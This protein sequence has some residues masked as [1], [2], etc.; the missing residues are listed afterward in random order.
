MKKF[1]SRLL[2]SALAM[3][4]VL[5]FSACSTSG[6]SGGSDSIKIGGITPLT[7]EV[8]V[9]GTSAKEGADLAFEE[10]N[11]A[12]G[13][14]GKKIE[15]NVLNDNGQAPDALQALN[16]HIS[17]KVAAIWG[18]AT[19]KPAIAMAQEAANAGILMMTPSASH[20]DVTKP[21]DNI[22]R[23]CFLDPVQGNAMA[24]FASGNLSA[25]TAAILYNTSDDYSV[26]LADAFEARA[27]ELGLDIIAKE[28]Y[29]ATDKDY[30]TQLTT[31]AGK[32]PDVLFVPDY[33]GT[34]ALIAQQAREIGLTVPILGGD[35][36][37]GVVDSVA[38][39]NR[40]VLNDVY[41]SNHYSTED[42]SDTV[43]NF[44]DAY[45]KKYNKAPNSF[46]ALGYDSAYLIAKAIENAGVSDDNAKIVDAMK[47]LTYDGV[48]GQFSFPD[49]A[50]TP[51]TIARN[52]GDPMKSVTIVKIQDGAYT[53]VERVN[54]E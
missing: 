10:I 16:R 27:K 39:S 3:V 14:L 31:I 17:D 43:K 28:G 51:S 5:S 54:A 21:G 24:T 9:Y 44:V 50:T 2:C 19:S 34:D 53:F 18:T 7:G 26:G 49:P 13:V 41:F 11:A 22:F 40:S 25:K 1:H 12:G 48:T 42:T 35:G 8:A 38:E 33:Y 32:T 15:F 20:P 36:W 47:A 46:A 29:G 4:S 6:G 45:T 37:D 52:I 30:K 23:T